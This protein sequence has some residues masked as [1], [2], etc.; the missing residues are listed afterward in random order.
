VTRPPRLS[1]AVQA[2]PSRRE[3]AEALASGLPGGSVVYDPDPDG[4]RSAWRTYRLVLETTPPDASHRL[5]AQDDVE[6]CPHF[7]AAAAAAI[8]ARPD[9]VIA[10]FVAGRPPEHA[11]AIF[12]ACRAGSHWAD[13]RNDRWCPAI[14]LAWPTDLIGPFLEFVDAQNWPPS[15]RADDEIIGRFL[16]HAGIRAAAT[17]PSLVEHWDVEPSVFRH[18]RARAGADLGRVAACYIH[19]EDDAR[20]IDWA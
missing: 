10:F 2:H 15:F 7:A 19:S 20:E 8:A 5:I 1:F 4:P 6:V 17:V 14:A 16:R 3:A 9:R 12:A 18:G 11:A 13:L